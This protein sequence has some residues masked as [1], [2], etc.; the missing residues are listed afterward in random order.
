MPREEPGNADGRHTGADGQLPR[1]ERRAPGLSPNSTRYK[2]IQ[3]HSRGPPEARSGTRCASPALPFR[4]AGRLPRARQHCAHQYLQDYQCMMTRPTQ[5]CA[6]APEELVST[7]RMPV[8]VSSCYFLN[9]RTGMVECV[10]TLAATL[11]MIK[12]P[13]P[14]RPCEAMMMR[15]APISFAFLM[16]S[17]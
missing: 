16:I 17:R 8:S 1:D 5:R 10:R 11:P 6:L 13:T 14:P 4:R 2:P 3:T 12:A 9:I 7:R 15:S